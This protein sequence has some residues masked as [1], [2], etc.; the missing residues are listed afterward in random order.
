MV[1]GSKHRML[2]DI[3]S[4]FGWGSAP[5]VMALLLVAPLCA[6]ALAQRD[7]STARS[8]QQQGVAYLDEHNLLKAVEEFRAAV[9][10]APS[11]PAAHDY[12]GIALAESN[13][14]EEAAKEFAVAVRLS[15]DFA[16]AHFHLAMA[17]NLLGRSAEA[18]REFVATLR[19]EPQS[20]D[21]R[22][23]LSAACWKLGDYEGAIQLL[24]QV[25][26]QNPPFAAEAH[27]NLGLELKQIGQLKEATRELQAAVGLEPDSVGYRTALCQT[28]T[29]NLDLDGALALA[30]E[31]IKLAP[32]NPGP[33]FDLAEASRVKGDL[34]TAEAQFNQTLQLDPR[35]PRA[36]RQLGLVLRQKGLY[37]AAV[38]QLQEAVQ[39]DSNDAEVRYLLG[40]VYLKLNE[41]QHA[42]ENLTESVS[43]NPYDSA[44]HITLAAILNRL[45]RKDEAQ[46]ELKKAQALDDL[47]ANAGRSRILLGSAAE[48]VRKGEIDAAIGELRNATE[49][50]PEYTEAH[51]Q[52]VLA[53]QKK[54]APAEQVER[55]LR[56]VIELKPDYAPAYLQMGLLLQREGQTE[57][58]TE[59]FHRAVGLAPSLVD[60]HRALAKL[61]QAAH[62]WRTA[63]AEFG[64]ILV[65]M[66]D[67]R[68][69][70]R[71]LSVSLAQR[72]KHPK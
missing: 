54:G 25:L 22:Y 34:A 64:A 58:A 51:F 66:D 62:D 52:L 47:K 46:E 57:K 36:H 55:S 50:S 70:R 17:D 37:E 68:E 33:H 48:H 2:R 61:A 42:L 13:Q 41:S 19:I 59:E 16:Q 27:Y 30:Q 9:A 44:A 40:S 63:V 43:S 60:A 28:L 8:H 24:R 32:T 38:G 6:A 29:E 4:I 26:K 11:D 35:F 1:S 21:A 65:W 20:I 39:E 31:T 10:D 23:A 12:L 49:L 7:V 14:N 56:R 45:G 18:I 69:A 53:L 3:T 5:K 71:G 67:D 15:E 72:K